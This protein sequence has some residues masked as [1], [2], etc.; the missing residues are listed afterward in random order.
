MSRRHSPLDRLVMRADLVLRAATRTGLRQHRATPGSELPDCPLSGTEKRH[1]AGLMRVNHA[2]EVCAQALYVGQAA[3]ARDQATFAE[4]T[5]AASEEGDHLFWCEA[6]LAELEAKTSRLNPLWF[7]GAYVIGSVAALLGDKLSLGFVEET[8]KQVVRHLDS[9]LD[10]LPADDN[11]SRAIVLAM[12]DDEA[13][14]AAAAT[15][16]G[17]TPL[18]RVVKTLMAWNASVMTTVAYWW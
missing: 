16:R 11:H 1:A 14:H 6:R 7:G 10:S 4:L 12:R 5:S 2:G 13:R 18:P 8:E 3:L 15:A 17:A 9:H